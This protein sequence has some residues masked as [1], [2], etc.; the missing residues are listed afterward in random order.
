MIPDSFSSPHVSHSC[1]ET[2]ANPHVHTYADTYTLTYTATQ[3][4][5]YSYTLIHIHIPVL[6]RAT[7]THTHLG[8]HTQT[9][10][11]T[12]S[13][14]LWHAY[15]CTHMLTHPNIHSHTYFLVHAHVYA[16]SPTFIVFHN[17]RHKITHMILVHICKHIPEHTCWSTGFF[18]RRQA[19]DVWDF[20][21]QDCLSMPVVLA[22]GSQRTNNQAPWMPPWL[23]QTWSNSTFLEVRVRDLQ[24]GM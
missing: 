21:A 12:Y 22:Q 10:T 17:H 2:P 14:T 24:I 3:I 9:G 20:P 8:T 23:L 13:Y 11:H 19:W 16:H 6:T 15:S 7:L 18:P 4:C 1:N 5:T